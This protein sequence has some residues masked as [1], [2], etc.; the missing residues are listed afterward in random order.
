MTDTSA[1]AFGMTTAVGV[2]LATLTGCKAVGPDYRRPDIAAPVV[3]RDAGSSASETLAELS[4]WSV[5][6]D[7]AL[8]G[9]IRVALTNSY[10]LR[11]VLTRE[12]QARA[13]KMQAESQFLPG[14]GYG[15]TA[16][17]GG[18]TF[19]SMPSLD[20]GRCLNGFAGGFQAVWEIDLWGRVRR[21]NE[22][23]R[24]KYMESVEGRRAVTVSVVGGVARV[25]FELL[26]LDDQRM[27]ARRTETSY[28]RTLA[29]FEDQHANGLASKLELAR[30]Q[31]A[32]H[33][34][35]AKIP[36]IERQIAMK[37][38][39]LNVLLGCNPGP[40][41]RTSDLLSQELPACVPAGLPSA[42]LERRP[43][44]RMAEQRVREAN[45]E[46]G[47][48]LGDFFPRVGLTTFVGAMST[49]LDQITKDGARTWSLAADAAGPIFTGGSLTGRYRQAKAACEE[50]KL[51]YRQA[52]LSAFRE[53]S[54]ALV[55]RV[56]LDA[57]RAEQAEAVAA[58]RDAVQV[59]T[60]RYAAG[61]ASYYEVL[62]A[63]QQLFPAETALSQLEAGR[64]L[65]LVQLYQ[66]LGGGWSLKDESDAGQGH[67]KTNAPETKSGR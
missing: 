67:S 58:C 50:A 25:Y 43:D 59:S 46:V 27:I 54:D 22:A 24:A 37:E 56:K 44:I 3:Y 5:F 61:K 13:L 15:G 26:E 41:H 42:L 32:L 63:Q 34:V 45:A 39:E 12:D 1:Y 29:L 52:A 4:W 49:D 9:L 64:R 33:T 18:N 62:E 38:N 21:M 47:V 31:A 19:L 53:V 16:S 23:A 30:A 55:S 48:T 20:G 14:L 11:I 10:D 8:Q 66:A 60:E 51:R 35:S 36:E 2:A 57:A 6:K 28:R 65:V 40:V 17:R 7:P